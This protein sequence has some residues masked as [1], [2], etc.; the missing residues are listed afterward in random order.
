[1]KMKKISI[2]VLVAAI[3]VAAGLST[4]SCDSVKKAKLSND[5]DSVSY[6]VG[7]NQG[8]SIQSQLP[9]VP[10]GP[11]NLD[12][13][14][15]GFIA[16]IQN[17]S[18][19]MKM[20]VAEAQ[21][22]MQQWFP[23][24]QA[25]EGEKTRAEGT[26]FLEENKTKSGVVTTESGLQYQVIT[27]GSG[28]KPKATDTVK[29]HYTGTLLDGSEFDSSAGGEPVTFA[30]NQVIPGWTEGLQIMPQ[31]SKY[32]FWIPSDMAYGERG[33]YNIK[34]N[35]LLKFE[36]ELLEVFQDKTAQP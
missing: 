18:T 28:I 11:L 21:A 33:S 16:G 19:K 14:I 30:L 12:D 7:L 34:P 27:E 9:S 25:R 20:T 32:I 31:G 17:D 6:A 36:V 13:M 8:A 15:A 2:S 10:G 5:V 23:Q 26:K 29:V 4:A 22:Y 1:M 35:S 24:A 3:L